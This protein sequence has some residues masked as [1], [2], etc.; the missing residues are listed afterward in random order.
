[1]KQSKFMSLM[2]S[3]INILVGFGVSC[4]AN[5]LVLPLFGFNVT[6]HDAVKIGVVMTFI[7]IAR[8]FTLR[9]VFEEV[10]IRWGNFDPFKK[11]WT[12]ASV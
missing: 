10:R 8:S 11:G 6:F 9:R 12:H 7:S 2:E 4:V 3:F 1:M 5:V